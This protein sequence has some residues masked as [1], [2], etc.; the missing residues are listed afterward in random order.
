MFLIACWVSEALCQGQL[1]CV[2]VQV[3]CWQ[4]LNLFSL[5]PCT[6]ADMSVLGFRLLPSSGSRGLSMDNICLECSVLCNI[7]GMFVSTLGTSS[8]VACMSSQKQLHRHPTFCLAP[9]ASSVPLERRPAVFLCALY[10]NVSGVHDGPNPVN[11][12]TFMNPRFAH[13]LCAT[14]VKTNKLVITRGI[15]ESWKTGNFIAARTL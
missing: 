10:L 8:Q 14:H 3:F 6:L 4:T 2:E 11:H 5:W 9:L 15:K 7:K 1:H 13:S 12:E